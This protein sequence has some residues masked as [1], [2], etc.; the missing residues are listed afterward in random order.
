MNN[1]IS[2][3]DRLPRCFERV[4]A[5]DGAFVGEAYLTSAHSRYRHTG[6]P[7]R[8]MSGKTVTHWMPLPE[9]PRENERT[10]KTCQ[11]QDMES[12]DADCP[13]WNC[14]GADNPEW[15]PKEYDHE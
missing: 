7:W 1:W 12:T 2:V 3:E 10:C 4:L 11:H 6:Y 13:C 9:P 14:K 5:T 8:A 15:E